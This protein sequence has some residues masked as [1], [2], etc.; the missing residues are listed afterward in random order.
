[1]AVHTE[2]MI[3]EEVTRGRGEQVGAHTHR[4]MASTMEE[5]NIDGFIYQI[6]VHSSKVSLLEVVQIAQIVQTL[7]LSRAEVAEE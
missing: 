5:K 6:L 1:M 3:R 2:T 4:T 7:L